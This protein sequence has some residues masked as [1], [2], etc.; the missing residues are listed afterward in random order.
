MRV[1]IAGRPP[2]TNMY[3]SVIYV[4][5]GVA[6]FGIVFEA[7]YRKK[8]VLTAAATVSTMALILADHCPAILDPSVRPLEPVLRSNY[9]LV[10]H[11]MTIALSY[12]AFALALGIANIT[13]GYYLFRSDKSDTIRRIEPIHIQSNPSRRVAARSRHHSGRRLGRLFLGPL[14]GMGPEG[15]LG[16][17]GAVGLFGRASCAV[18]RRGRPSRPG[19][20]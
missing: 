2:V 4:G 7:I 3:E 10:T 18:R 19:R 14:L 8:Y 1:I 5:S 9:W 6:I 16:P 12:A 13:L 15:S 17:G 11:V 20:D